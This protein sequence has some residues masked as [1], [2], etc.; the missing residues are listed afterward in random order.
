[1][2]NNKPP[3]VLVNKAIRLIK[4]AWDS[5]YVETIRNCWYESGLISHKVTQ[6]APRDVD[7]TIQ[8]DSEFNNLL[9]HV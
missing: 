9:T 7:H 6:V 2:D 1:M 8:A 3:A 5:V 4:K